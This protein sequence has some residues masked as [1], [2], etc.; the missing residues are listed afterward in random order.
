MVRIDV[1]Q[2]I[3]PVQVEIGIEL[4]VQNYGEIVRQRR[5]VLVGLLSGFAPV[6]TRVD[7]AIHEQVTAAVVAGLEERLRP[8]LI[9]R[10]NQSLTESLRSSLAQHL[11]ESGV[12][13]ELRIRVHGR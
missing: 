3:A 7:A 1:Q 5:G 12:E 13:A 6:R 8:E 10:L 2:E 4:D 11:S 9:E